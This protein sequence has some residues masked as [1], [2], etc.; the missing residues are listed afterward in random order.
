MV[1]PK[2][3]LKKFR[4]ASTSLRQAV[5]REISRTVC[6][7]EL[8]PWLLEGTRN[9]KSSS[10]KIQKLR[11]IQRQI[12]RKIRVQRF[13]SSGSWRTQVKISGQKEWSWDSSSVIHHWTS[14]WR[15]ISL[16][17]SLRRGEPCWLAL[18][19]L[20]STHTIS[21]SCISRYN[22]ARNSML[23]TSLST[24][25][26]TQEAMIWAAL[27]MTK[28]RASCRLSHWSRAWSRSTKEMTSTTMMSWLEWLLYL[29]R[30]DLVALIDV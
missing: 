12:R 27:L 16:S 3:F 29:K 2:T 30:R 22:M 14:Q 19:Y 5:T 23:Q 1:Q 6:S 24:W 7:R 17:W 10:A 21:W 20:P 26:L 13:H 25:R 9:F 4:S 15:A 11:S 28:V 18:I 8:S